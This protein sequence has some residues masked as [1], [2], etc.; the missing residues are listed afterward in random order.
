MHLQ[1]FLGVA[2]VVQTNYSAEN[3]LASVFVER[4][5][6]GDIISDVLKAHKTESCSLQGYG[7]T[8]K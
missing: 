5:S 1:T 7:F 8:K 6:Y 2:V 3:L 4:N